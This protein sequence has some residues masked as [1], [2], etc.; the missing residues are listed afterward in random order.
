RSGGKGNGSGVGN[1]NGINGGSGNGAGGGNGT[2]NGLGNGPKNFGTKIM[3][4]SNQSF[5]DEFN[6]NAKVAMD[7]V[8]DDRG[9]VQSATF[10]PRGSTTSNHKLIDIA[11]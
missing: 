11:E 9:K 1:G 7:I 8:A 3:Q 4:I 5:E 10:Q 2:G 6:E